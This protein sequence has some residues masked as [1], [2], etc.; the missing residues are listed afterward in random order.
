MPAMLTAELRYN[1]E[2]ENFVANFVISSPTST[3]HNRASRSGAFAVSGMPAVMLASRFPSGLNA[4][5][6]M[7]V[8]CPTSVVCFFQALSSLS[9]S[10]VGVYS[11]TWILCSVS[12]RASLCCV[13][14]NASARINFASAAMSSA[15]GSRFPTSQTL[16]RFPSLQ[17]ESI[18]PLVDR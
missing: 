2:S 1:F 17:V 8:V 13:G 10:A 3:S 6:K 9:L 11:Q 14:A 18:F 4:T 5:P 16:R 15:T 12:T 7:N